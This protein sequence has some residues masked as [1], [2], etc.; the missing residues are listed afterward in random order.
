MEKVVDKKE[1][2][3][4]TL[5]VL[6]NFVTR[7]GNIFL[8]YGLNLWIINISGNTKT[9]GVISS[10]GLLP[11]ILFTLFG[12]I[13]SDSYN[14]KNIVIACDIIAGIV[15]AIMAL[16]I[17]VER[18]DITS[19]VI[20]RIIMSVIQSLFKP[21]INA[22]PA[23]S[24]KQE[25][26]KQFNSILNISSQSIQVV[27][28]LVSSFFIIALGLNIKGILLI[29]SI[30]FICSAISEFFI[31]LDNLDKKISTQKKFIGNKLKEGF[32]YISKKKYIENIIILASLSNIFIAGYNLY[33]PFYANYIGDSK[34]YGI[35][36]SVEAI[37]GIL[38]ALTLAYKKDYLNENRISINLFLSGLL[39]IPLVFT[40]NKYFTCVSIF[41]FGL[42]LTRFNVLLFTYL[43]N[44]VE[45]EFLGR[46][47]S[48]VNVTA[49]I[50]MPLGQLIF[51]FGI[52]YF[53]TMTVPILGFFICLLSLI[54]FIFEKK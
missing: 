44:N 5:L 46:V 21:S 9:L 49:I 45:K 24:I 28:P 2:V 50:L 40:H 8:N 16:V 17:N 42:F 10:I 27:G 53:K 54:S 3:N 38:G 39:F 35:M 37:G 11:I 1:Y 22:L 32:Q 12:G 41:A 19:I 14:K 13:V 47:L 52:D 6:G 31:K 30:T 33:L 51:G 15:C 36:L 7:F 20:F 25:H 43:Q 34:L 26:R 4:G 29:D 48:I 23:Y 18:L